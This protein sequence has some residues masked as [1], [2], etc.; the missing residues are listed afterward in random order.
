MTSGPVLI[1]IPAAHRSTNIR[2]TADG[3]PSPSIPRS[4]SQTGRYHQSICLKA[5]RVTYTTGSRVRIAK[6]VPVLRVD[7]AA[8]G[9]IHLLLVVAL[10]V[11]VINLVS[12]RSVP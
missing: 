3:Y 4:L 8:G 1:A 9:L 12:G 11:L 10:V 5:A 7:H 6:D 2:W